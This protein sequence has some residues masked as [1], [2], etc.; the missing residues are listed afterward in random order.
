MTLRVG[1]SRPIMGV[2]SKEGKGE[3]EFVDLRGWGQ[4]GG[5]EVG[6]PGG[7]DGIKAGLF[8]A[9]GGSLGE[10]LGEPLWEVVVA[11]GG[12]MTSQYR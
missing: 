12:A 9:V 11:A 10:S 5:G 2:I 6:I 7:V 3:R 1:Y 4:D 8:K